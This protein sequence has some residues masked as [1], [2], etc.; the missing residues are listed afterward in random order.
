MVVFPRADSGATPV[1]AAECCVPAINVLLFSGDS[2]AHQQFIRLIDLVRHG[3]QGQVLVP[4]GT[5]LLK[6]NFRHWPVHD[7]SRSRDMILAI[8]PTHDE[9]LT[10]QSL[11]PYSVMDGAQFVRSNESVSAYFAAVA[12]Q[13]ATNLCNDSMKHASVVGNACKGANADNRSTPVEEEASRGALF[14]LVF[15]SDS[16]TSRPRTDALAPCVPAAQSIVHEF[17]PKDVHNFQWL[18]EGVSRGLTLVHDP[19]VPSLRSLGVRIPMHVISAN[20]WELH[21]SPTTY[22]WLMRMATGNCNVTT[23][24]LRGDEWRFGE[25]PTSDVT[26]LYRASTVLW[27]SPHARSRRRYS[28]NEFKEPSRRPALSAWPPT[29]PREVARVETPFR[30]LHDAVTNVT[31]SDPRNQTITRNSSHESE[32]HRHGT[33]FSRLRV[34]DMGKVFLATDNVVHQQDGLHERCNG[35]HWLVGAAS[36]SDSTR[37]LRI[38]AEALTREVFK[39]LPEPHHVPDIER[40]PLRFDYSDDCDGFG[41]LVTLNALLLDIVQQQ[42]AA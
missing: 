42:Q 13:R 26:H 34:L 28:P 29:G 6:S 3:P 32:R 14:Y 15:L 16:I 39:I 5:E 18:K 37:A 25:H 19:P 21:E 33:F 27:V 8:Y 9:L 12:K 41:T 7:R 24:P 10:F 20:I 2:I 1:G 30:W 31:G 4:Y 40:V 17:P 38:S 36:Y 35:V 22:E 11:L 23:A